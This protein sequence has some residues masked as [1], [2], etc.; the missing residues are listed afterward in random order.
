MK[1][2]TTVF[3]QSR[4][5][6]TDNV[7][8]SADYTNYNYGYFCNQWNVHFILIMMVRLCGAFEKRLVLV[9]SSGNRDGF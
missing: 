3:Q 9:L 5:L 4:N 1:A 7:A 2:S 6:I 8:V